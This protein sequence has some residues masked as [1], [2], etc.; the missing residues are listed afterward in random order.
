MEAR[1]TTQGIQ[2][3]RSGASDAAISWSKVG[4]AAFVLALSAASWVA[5]IQALEALF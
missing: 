5:I 1:V 2:S 4:G 3:G